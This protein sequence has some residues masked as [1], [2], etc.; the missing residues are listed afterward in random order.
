MEDL[1]QYD[2]ENSKVSVS[3]PWTHDV[4]KLSDNLNQAIKFQMSVE[5]KLRK[6]KLMLDAYNRELRKFI[7]RGAL[8]K[9]TQEEMDNYSGPVSYVSHHAV[10]KPGSVT[11]PIRIVTN[12][13]L[14]NVKAGIS[15][16]DC[17]QEGPNALSSLL[18]VL[19]GFRLN[20]VAL[21]YDMTKAYQSIATGNIERHVRRI[22]WRWGDE[23]ASWEIYAY[24]VVTFGDR[25]AGLVL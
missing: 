19:I 18:E 9:L 17:M 3:Y 14:V 22:I 6:D 11:T 8:I 16:N 12:S 2:A 21:A 13:S 20:E 15:P 24:D 25:I 1:I 10:M 5:R 4:L 7:D 23:T